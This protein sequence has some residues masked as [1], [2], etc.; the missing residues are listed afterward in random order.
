MALDRD[1]LLKPVKKL[2][3]LIAGLDTN[4]LPETVH[5][6]RTSTRRFEAAYKALSLDTQGIGK[7]MLKDLGR[8]RK[9]AGKVRDMDVLTGF[10]STV[11]PQ[12]DKAQAEAECSVQLLEHLGAQRRKHAKKLVAE[13]D[14]LGPSLRRDLKHASSVMD[15]L[16]PGKATKAG[17]QNGSAAATD[18]TAAAVKLAAGL[19]IPERL[20]RE[21]LHPYRLKVKELRN[22]LQMAAGASRLKFV[23]DLGEV[24]DAIGEWHDWEELVAIARKVLDHR[25]GCGLQTELKHIAG[26]KYER[27]LA[28]AKNLRK[29]YLRN[30][31]P[32]GKRGAAALPKIPSAPIWEATALLAG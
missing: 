13:A 17:A 1:R 32:S 22:V 30:A 28:V 12:G 20:D 6:L 25:T 5:D 29:T 27:A 10:A 11:H 23:G 2:R 31:P 24:K 26:Q 14:R 9:R 3:K 8:L 19:W 21:T 16:L 18:A 7:S 4:P 15:K